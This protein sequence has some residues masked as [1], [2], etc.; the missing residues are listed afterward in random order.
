[1]SNTNFETEKR[2]RILF[3]DDD[4][5]LRL[6]LSE[7]LSTETGYHVEVCS[8]GEEAI[9][10]LKRQQF[11]V[12][13]LDYKMPGLSG[14]NV[15]QWMYE[16]KMDTPVLMFTG[17]GTETVAVEAMKLGAYD[18]IRKEH[19]EIYHLPIIVNGVYE[20]YLFKK[21]KEQRKKMEEEQTKALQDVEALKESIT[22][23]V[24]VISDVLAKLSTQPAT[25]ENSVEVLRQQYSVI[26]F[27]F[28][29]LLDTLNSFYEKVVQARLSVPAN[30]SLQQNKGE[31]LNEKVS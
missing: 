3:A 4:D 18:Y 2:L 15:L 1:M 29:S 5:S 17:A 6:T 24:E 19:V 12:V 28:R 27:G 7:Y 14:L 23:M 10:L 16:Q 13:L 31:V 8:N 11:D 21:E 25:D 20:R 22:A 26:V 9:E 30:H